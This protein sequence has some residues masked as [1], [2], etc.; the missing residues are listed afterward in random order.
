MVTRDEILDY[1]QNYL[2]VSDFS[3]YCVNGLQVEGTNQI[4]GIVTGVSASQ[5]LFQKALDRQADL[6]ITHHGL[7][8][9]SQKTP[10]SI[11]GS[12]TE[13]LKI[14]LCNNINLAAYHLPLD[15]HP[16]IGNNALLL[17]KMDFPIST[18]FD[19]GFISKLDTGLNPETLKSIL[20][21]CL[22]MP[23]TLFGRIQ[24]KIQTIAVISGGGSGMLEEASINGA[25]ALIT[26]DISEPSVRIAE[27][28]D[29]CLYRAGHYNTERLGVI[30][31][32]EH[33]SS[34]FNLPSVFADIPN[35]V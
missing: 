18:P 31:L 26:G 5:K 2:S 34:R 21:S 24:K 13:R 17:E 7:F 1:L 23:S 15:A 6:V 16:V 35:P 28:L 20:D 10:F 4:T 22:P 14:L 11:T 32:A 27:E 30:A 25:D 29:I 12:I 8:W 9:K 19:V 33:L 3:D